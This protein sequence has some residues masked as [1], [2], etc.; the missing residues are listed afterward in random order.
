MKR[1]KCKVKKDDVE[2]LILIS[3]IDLDNL[4]LLKEYL[5]K[6]KK[7]DYNKEEIEAINKYNNFVNNLLINNK[8]IDL[9]IDLN[10][11]FFE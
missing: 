9:N 3:K 11:C 4:K 10:I 6:N 2:V 8:K 7:T 5:P 1:Y